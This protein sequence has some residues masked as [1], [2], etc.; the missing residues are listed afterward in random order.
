MANKRTPKPASFD[1]FLITNNSQWESKICTSIKAC[2]SCLPRLPRSLLLKQM[3]TFSSPWADTS[4][5]WTRT[6]SS[7]CG[8]ECLEEPH[9]VQDASR[10]PP[11]PARLGL[12]LGRACGL[13]CPSCP[14]CLGQTNASALAAE[15]RAASELSGCALPWIAFPTCEP[16]GLLHSYR[17]EISKGSAPSP[18]HHAPQE[19]PCLASGPA[20]RQSCAGHRCI[21]VFVCP[22]CVSPH[23]SVCPGPSAQ[24]LLKQTLPLAQPELCM[25]VCTHKWHVL[26]TAG[27]ITF[28]RQISGFT[29]CFKWGATEK[30]GLVSHSVSWSALCASW[31]TDSIFCLTQYYVLRQCSVPPKLGKSGMKFPTT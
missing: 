24:Q 2:W 11:W 10:W 8:R 17:W 19:H 16:Q 27:K 7:R 26:I 4:P 23:P 6:L 14:D 31:S 30:G 22:T 20:Q 18:G 5:G 3:C 21:P 25:A 9:A 15:L 12:A 28:L 13:P 1:R 29:L